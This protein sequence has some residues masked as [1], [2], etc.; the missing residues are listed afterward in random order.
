MA[1]K[2]KNSSESETYHK[3]YNYYDLETYQKAFNY[4]QAR[5]NFELNEVDKD[6]VNTLKLIVEALKSI[7][8]LPQFTHELSA[9]DF[10]AIDKALTDAEERSKTVAEIRPPGCEGPY[11]V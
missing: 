3:S 7:K 11:P 8:A 4:G 5:I 10:G 9:I 6:F 1:T 2:Q